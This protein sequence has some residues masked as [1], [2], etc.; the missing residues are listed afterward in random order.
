MTWKYILKNEPRPPMPEGY[1]EEEER[2]KKERDERRSKPAGQPPMPP[3][4]NP[5][6][7][8][9]EIAE[10]TFLSIV[11]DRLV[12]AMKKLGKSPYRFTR[13]E[14]PKIYYLI[15]SMMESDDKGLVRGF[16]RTYQRIPKI[17]FEPNAAIITIGGRL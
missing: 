15:K 5:S 3:T 1:Y 16:N 4:P 10:D 7:P 9:Q 2:K 14:H 13:E 17:T 6:R 8:K 12:P 11:Q